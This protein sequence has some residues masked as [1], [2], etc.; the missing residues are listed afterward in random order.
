VEC[1]RLVLAGGRVARPCPLWGCAMRRWVLDSRQAGLVCRVSHPGVVQRAPH[2]CRRVAG[3][4]RSRWLGGESVQ[5]LA[6]DYMV[7][8]N[9]IRRILARIG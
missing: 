7:P 4:N 1:V 6:Q 3:A 8:A 5:S 9:V 2:P